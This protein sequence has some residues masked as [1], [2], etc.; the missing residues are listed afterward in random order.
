MASA[1][2]ARIAALAREHPDHRSDASPVNAS[3]RSAARGPV[4]SLDLAV[5]LPGPQPAWPTNARPLRSPTE[6][7]SGVA[8]V[9]S[10]P[11]SSNASSAASVG[12]SNSPSTITAEGWTGPPMNRWS[13]SSTSSSSCGT[14]SLT[15]VSTVGRAPGRALP[16]GVLDHEHDR[17][18]EVGVQQRRSR[19]QELARGRSPLPTLCYSTPTPLSRRRWASNASPVASADSLVFEVKSGEVGDHLEQIHADADLRRRSLPARRRARR[20][21][22]HLATPRS[23][24]RWSLSSI[25]L[26]LSSPPFWSAGPS[27]RPKISFMISS[28]PPPIGP[29]ARL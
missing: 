17:A 4:A 29:S 6:D 16:L 20:T 24:H 5:E 19:N 18:P 28:V 10:T 1:P 13:E 9:P 22:R 7:S 11:T 8:P 26:H 25:A 15:V 23:A 14:A 3:S 2:A 21:G 27:D 12:S